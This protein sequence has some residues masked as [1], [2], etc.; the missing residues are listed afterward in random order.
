MSLRVDRLPTLSLAGTL[1]GHSYR[2]EIGPPKREFIQGSELR[3]RGDLDLDA[4]V[5]VI[6]MSRALKCS[7]EEQAYSRITDGDQTALRSDLYEEMR[8]VA[9]YQ[10]VG[11]AGLTHAFWERFAV[12][13]DRREHAQAWID[14]QLMELLGVG[15]SRPLVLV[16]LRGKCFLRMQCA[17]DDVHDIQLACDIFDVACKGALKHLGAERG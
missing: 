11:W 13:S 1:D 10:E 16:L 17:A 4:S 15:M 7:L 5:G 2:I 12:L 6:V 9:A 3:A 14:D 8:W